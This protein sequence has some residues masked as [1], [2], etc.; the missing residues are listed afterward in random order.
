MLLAQLLGH[1][2]SNMS[3]DRF[4]YF[5]EKRP[6][7]EEIQ[8]VLEDYFRDIATSIE[9][10]QDGNRFFVN[11]PGKC[12]HPLKRVLPENMAYVWKA[13]DEEQR[14]RW[15][16]VYL[17]RDNIDVI[18]RMQDEVTAHLADGFV[19]VVARWWQGRVEDK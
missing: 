1:A 17:G 8:F 7:K 19:K 5:K 16:E 18:T 10:R 2:K 14:E 12:Y 13:F 4:I 6:T 3:A 9:W 15:I 11:L